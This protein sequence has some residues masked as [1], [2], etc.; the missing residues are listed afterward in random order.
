MKRRL[1][2][3]ADGGLSDTDLGS[4]LAGRHAGGLQAEYLL[5]LRRV[6]RTADRL[7]DT[8]SRRGLARPK[9]GATLGKFDSGTTSA[10]MKRPRKTSQGSHSLV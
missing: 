2:R 6:D 9:V 5:L 3:S 8:A 4:D 10:A 1:R 7:A